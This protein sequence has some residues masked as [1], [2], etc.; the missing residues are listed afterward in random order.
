MT[1]TFDSDLQTTFTVGYKCPPLLI[2]TFL[3][4]FEGILTADCSI[5]TALRWPLSPPPAV[6]ANPSAIPPDPLAL[7]P[8]IFTFPGGVGA[9]P[10]TAFTLGGYG[11]GGKPITLSVGDTKG[12]LPPIIFTLPPYVIGTQSTTTASPT[13]TTLTFSGSASGA[14]PTILTIGEVGGGTSPAT[15][16]VEAAPGGVAHTSSLTFGGPWP[17]GIA[18]ATPPGIGS[19]PRTMSFGGFGGVQPTWVMVEGTGG[20]AQPTTVTLEGVMARPLATTITLGGVEAEAQTTTITMGGGLLVMPATTTITLTQPPEIIDG[21]N[22]PTITVVG[23]EGWVQTS[24]VTLDGV[25]RGWGIGHPMTDPPIEEPAA[26]PKPTMINLPGGYKPT[27]IT[28]GGGADGAGFQPTTISLERGGGAFPTTIALGGD[29][30]GQTNP[31]SVTLPGGWGFWGIPDDATTTTSSSA[32]PGPPLPVWKHWPAA[33]LVAIRK[34]D[35]DPHEDGTTDTDCFYILWIQ[36]CIVINIDL[37]GFKWR[38]PPGIYPP[39]PPPWGVLKF[40][41]IGTF[42]F[43]DDPPPWPKITIGWDQKL[44]YSD[45]R[46]TSCQTQTAEFCSIM[47][48]VMI[49]SST[50]RRSTIT[51]DC[52]TLT[53]CSEPARTEEATTTSI[54]PT[55]S[56]PASSTSSISSTSSTSST[57]SSSACQPTAS[58]HVLVCYNDAIVYPVDPA[59]VG[60]IPDLLVNY[61]GKYQTVEAV[62]L[63]GFYWVPALDL[64]TY[65][66]LMASPDVDGVDYYEERNAAYRGVTDTHNPEDDYPSAPNVATGGTSSHPPQPTSN[67]DKKLVSREVVGSV[68]DFWEMGVGSLPKKEPFCGQ[69]SFTCQLYNG[70]PA[71]TYWWDTYGGWDATNNQGWTVY[72]VGEA[73]IYDTHSEFESSSIQHIRDNV[74]YGH[75]PVDPTMPNPQAAHGSGVISHIN[76][77][78][79]GTCKRC[80][81]V[82]TLEL[83]WHD[84]PD[85]DP[86]GAQ[87][88]AEFYMVLNDVNRNDG[89]LKRKAVVNCSWKSDQGYVSPHLIRAYRTILKELDKAGVVVVF[90]AGNNALTQG[91]E[92]NQWPTLLANP[93]KSA[94]PYGQLK[95]LIVVGAS[96]SNGTDTEWGQTASYM[97]T[98][99][100][101]QDVELPWDPAEAGANNLYFQFNGTSWAAPQVAGVIAYLRSLPG[102]F[103]KPL[104][105]PKNVKKMVQFLAR[106]Y[107]V[108]DFDG[109]PVPVRYRDKRPVLW[110]G[111][112]QVWD[113]ANQRVT[114]YNCLKDWDTRQGWD[115]NGAC[116]G[117]DPDMKNMGSGES[118]QACNAPAGPSRKKL[119]RDD[120]DDYDYDDEFDSDSCPL[121]PDNPYDPGASSITFSSASVAQPTCTAAGGCGGTVCSGYYCAPSP[122][123]TP[124]DHQD[125]QD[126]VNGQPVSSSTVS[127]SW[128]TRPPA[129]TD[130]TSWSTRLSP[131]KTWSSSSSLT[132]TPN[133]TEPYPPPNSVSPTVNCD[134]GDDQCKVDM[135]YR[136]NCDTNGCDEWSPACCATKSC[137]NCVCFDGRCTSDSP[138]CCPDNCVWSWTGGYG[139]D[140]TVA[141][142]HML[143]DRLASFANSSA[144]S[145]S[146]WSHTNDTGSWNLVG[147]SGRLTPASVCTET[148]AWSASLGH[149]RAA[150]AKPDQ[151]G[152]QTW[153]ANVTVF[154]DTCSYLSGVAN[155]SSVAAGVKVGALT[156]SRWATADCY[157]ANHTDVHDCG[158]DKVAEELVCQW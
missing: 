99:A 2:K 147:Y 70:Y 119:R 130:L 120:S 125:P 61:T 66:K 22:P 65:G 154:N 47:T 64:E 156:C 1:F 76:G 36:I 63:T 158:T 55:A 116:E 78:N 117:L 58:G 146:L 137:P 90:A 71:Y 21:P 15:I 111:H 54:A 106:R 148:P 104:R 150:D 151:V 51:G 128:S 81:V 96:T 143:N 8:G 123:G 100:P 40:P 113:Y 73:G 124:P 23:G 103:R 35:P 75:P 101:G 86:A 12:S 69:N 50:T 52:A 19:P 3:N 42:K 109:T 115:F 30:N 6:T 41:D 33:E 89:A 98:F 9:S 26:G 77:K 157:R 17:P 29:D 85:F 57:S 88:L 112:V 68:G 28:L 27:T 129:P 105:E 97:T 37:S 92:I 48:S 121:D 13:S 74:L 84:F 11:G 49:E 144:G 16:S 114:T 135:G 91:K 46:S 153:Y 38:F 152:L 87:E 62:G 118:V 7:P 136:C 127:R 24:T 53:G 140:K 31:T 10:I 142:S 122:S 34:D 60:E 138:K 110:N 45:E 79:L 59:N 44:T 94:N 25:W 145:Y 43:K 5:T 20:G 18:P 107:D 67:G 131:T 132:E 39:G 83:D 4:G 93:S 126:P 72:V 102:P 14:Q 80:R 56:T 133:P 141:V 134:P 32:A 108:L 95:N 149:G 139:G 82:W 155:Y